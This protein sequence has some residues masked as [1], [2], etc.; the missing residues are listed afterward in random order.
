MP[1]VKLKLHCWIGRGDN[2]D[3]NEF[4][5]KTVGVSAG[6]ALY[7][8]VR[9]LSAVN[10]LFRNEI[11]DETNQLIKEDVT[12]LL[13]GRL[14]NVSDPEETTLKDGDEVIFLPAIYGG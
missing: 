9:R 11:F 13:N 5:E 7:S 14:V 4:N 3:A 8:M 10:K 2:A 6:E 12:V 1:Q